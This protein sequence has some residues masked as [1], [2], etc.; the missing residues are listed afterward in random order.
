MLLKTLTLS[1]LKCTENQHIRIDAELHHHRAQKQSAINSL[2]HRAFTISDKEYLQT[3]LN[4]LKQALQ[5]NGHD[6]KD[7]NNQQTPVRQPQHTTITR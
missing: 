7:I 6:K 4:H 1:H 2:V 3:E 5:K